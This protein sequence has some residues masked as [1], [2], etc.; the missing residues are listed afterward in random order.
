MTDIEVKIQDV[1][2]KYPGLSVKKGDAGYILNG[3][4]VLNAEYDGI[5]LYD[6]YLLE[7]FIFR[8]QFHLLCII[9][10]F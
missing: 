4:I 6:E 1:C 3:T 10:K 2:E 5:P 8:E 7:I 9:F